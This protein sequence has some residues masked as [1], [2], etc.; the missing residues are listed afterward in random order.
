MA[1][2]IALLWVDFT[3]CS[4]NCWLL[5]KIFLVTELTYSNQYIAA[6]RYVAKPVSV[7]KTNSRKICLS[8][9]ICFKQGMPQ[10][11][12][13]CFLWAVLFEVSCRSVSCE[14][15]SS[16]NIKNCLGGVWL[17]SDFHIPKR[18]VLFASMKK[19]FKICWIMFILLQS[20]FC[21]YDI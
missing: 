3:F 1:L 19:P 10:N 13:V 20:S 14:L 4:F 7:S 9:Q 6:R 16:I 18:L 17:K 8:Y 21:S 12:S 5:G 11:T 2:L 15:L